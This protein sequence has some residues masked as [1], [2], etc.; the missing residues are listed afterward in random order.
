M[1]NTPL[2]R[3]DVEGMAEAA[4]DVD[5]FLAIRQDIPALIAWIEALEARQVKL[6]A[7]LEAARLLDPPSIR[8][9]WALAD[10]DGEGDG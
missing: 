8:I 10:L 5:A 3:P 6:G 4:W 9:G 1:T 2:P 7:V